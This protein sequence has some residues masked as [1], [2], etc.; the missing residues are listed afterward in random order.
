MKVTVLGAGLVGQAITYRLSKSTFFDEIV[1]IDINESNLKRAKKICEYN[2]KTIKANI[3]RNINIVEGSDIVCC[4]LPGSISF[5]VCRKILSLSIHVVDSSF[6]PRDP[7]ELHNLALDHNVIYIPDAGFAPGMSNIFVGDLTR[8]IKNVHKVEIYVGGLPIKPGG[9]LL[10]FVNWSL[11]DFIEEYI[12]PARIIRRGKQ[13]SV[14]PLGSIEQVRIHGEM[15]EAFYTDGLR[16]LL[17]TIKANYMFEKT[18]RYPGHLKKMR[19][20]RDLGFFSNELINI[21]GTKI[22]LRDAFIEVLRRYIYKPNLKDRVILY[23]RVESTKKKDTREVIIEE[24]FD[25]KLGLSAMGKTTGYTNAILAEAVVEVIRKRGVYPPEMFGFE[26][27]DYFLD[28]YFEEERIEKEE[29]ESKII[30]EKATNN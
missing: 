21:R 22:R 12:R 10:H 5:D 13:I 3:T 6:T 24:R 16:T 18:L 20:L 7:F 14:D 28:R 30:F 19:L 26:H 25:D 29:I 1:V 15:F 9:P 2:I 23:V 27:I 8:E 17:K 4:A 11:T